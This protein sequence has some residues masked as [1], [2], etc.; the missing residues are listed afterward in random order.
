VKKTGNHVSA[1]A[2]LKPLLAWVNDDV[3]LSAREVGRLLDRFIKSFDGSESAGFLR[4]AISDDEID[5]RPRSVRRGK[6]PEKSKVMYVKLG[7]RLVPTRIGDYTVPSWMRASADRA[8]A[9][10]L[11]EEDQLDVLQTVVADLLHRGFP[12]DDHVEEPDVV[13]DRMRLPSLQ[14]GVERVAHAANKRELASLRRKP[15]A[16]VRIV[17]G[18]RSDVVLYCLMHMLTLPGA[19]TLD[20][21]LA[22]QAFRGSP[23][24]WGPF[25]R[26]GRLFIR[27]TRG[28][29]RKQCSDNCTKNACKFRE[30]Y[31]DKKM[32][33]WRYVEWLDK[34]YQG[35]IKR[36]IERHE[37]KKRAHE[38]KVRKQAKEKEKRS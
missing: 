29:P 27:R 11:D 8:L 31:R 3:R 12:P 19:V 22:P 6:E 9:D 2:R 24:G 7:G 16:Y 32:P 35:R 37:R 18:K 34:Q 17:Q 5:I 33:E 4:A 26:C 25:R 28:A 23:R 15:G 1:P 36:D 14:F 10:G 30:R 21:C 13:P 20:R 38:R